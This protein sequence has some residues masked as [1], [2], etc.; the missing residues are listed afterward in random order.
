MV[1]VSRFHIR[2]L[3]LG[4]LNLTIFSQKSKLEFAVFN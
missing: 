2:L 4:Q 1:G 3:C